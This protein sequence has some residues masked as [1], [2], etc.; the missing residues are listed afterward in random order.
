VLTMELCRGLI[1]Q[2]MMSIAHPPLRPDCAGRM[3]RSLRDDA[4]LFR[5]R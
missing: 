5:D 3:L 2:K 4:S 1:A